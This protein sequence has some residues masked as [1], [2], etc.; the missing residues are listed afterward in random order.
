MYVPWR[1]GGDQRAHRKTLEA[2]NNRIAWK[3]R[4]GQLRLFLL[5]GGE[6]IGYAP[7]NVLLLK[8]RY[9]LRQDELPV[10]A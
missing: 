10:Q 5:G 8:P 2:K 1:G 4:Q 7:C 6:G 9:K 3:D